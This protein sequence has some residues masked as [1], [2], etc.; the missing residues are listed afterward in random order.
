MTK[1]DEERHRQRV[2]WPFKS[3]C[4]RR[5]GE[6]RERN[7]TYWQRDTRRFIMDQQTT[8]GALN[9][10]SPRPINIEHFYFI[11]G[12]ESGRINS[13]FGAVLFPPPNQTNV[14]KRRWW[15]N[16]FPKAYLFIYSCRAIIFS[17]TSLR[18]ELLS[19]ISHSLSVQLSMSSVDSDD[20][21]PTA[22]ESLHLQ[23]YNT[24]F[25]DTQVART[26]KKLI[27]PSNQPSSK[28]M[29][30]LRRTDTI[31]HQ[32]QLPFTLHGVQ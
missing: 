11:S 24:E 19:H 25:T 27:R 17:T 13:L 29:I 31:S 9:E 18:S 2:L 12:T 23:R 6:V 28:L 4:A 15:G 32:T 26:R 30:T 3:I 22:I 7:S 10:N 16:V 21:R 14:E 1:I 8:G 5:N 20:K